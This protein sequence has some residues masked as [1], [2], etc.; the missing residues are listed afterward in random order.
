MLEPEKYLNYLSQTKKKAVA[1]FRCST[2]KLNIEIGRHY[3]IPFHQRI[4]MYC[5]KE[6]NVELVENE[7]HFLFICPYYED[8]RTT[9]I[10]ISFRIYSNENKLIRFL[11][12]KEEYVILQLSLYLINAFKRRET[13][14][15]LPRS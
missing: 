9:Y 8:I 5:K 3:N 1:D 12:T 14:P 10:L 13:L 15:V 4:C 2:H 11:L 6:R 7:F